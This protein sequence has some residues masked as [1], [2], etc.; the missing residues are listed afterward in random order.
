MLRTFCRAKLSLV[1]LA[2]MTLRPKIEATIGNARAYLAM[3]EAGEDSPTSSGPWP[4]A[5]RF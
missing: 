3:A 4:A 2:Y 1:E 5:H